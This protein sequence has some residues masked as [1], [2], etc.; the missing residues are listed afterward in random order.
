MSFFSSKLTIIGLANPDLPASRRVGSPKFMNINIKIAIF[1]KKLFFVFIL[2]FIFN[3]IWENAHSYLYVHYQGGPITQLLLLR[4]AF[5]DAFF[6][7]TL[8]LFFQKKIRFAVIFAI[9]AAIILEKYALSSGR[10]AYNERMPIIPFL[11][12]GLTPTMQLGIL[13]FFIFKYVDKVFGRK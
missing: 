8:W 3:W 13:S 5:I 4:A 11:N 1:F 12:T 6:I 7:T 10:W 2:A 9:I